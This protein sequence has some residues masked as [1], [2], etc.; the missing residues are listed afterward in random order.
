MSKG[1]RRIASVVLSIGVAAV[2]AYGWGNGGH[3]AV[4]FVA[5]QD[6]T[7]QV[8]DRVDALIKLNPSYQAWMALIPANTP[9]A[10]RNE[11]LFMIAATWPD[12]I[13]GDHQHQADGT[14]GGDRPPDD[15]TA[16]Q[17]IGYGDMAMH[18]YWHF[19]DEPFTQ[20]G[21]PLQDPPTP[22]AE[23]QIAAF[24]ATLASDSPDALK[25]YD[26]VW[27]LHLVGDVHQPLHCASRF[28]HADPN[29]DSGGNKVVVCTGK[30]KA[31]AGCKGELH[32]FWDDLFGTSPKPGPAMKVGKS[33][34]A[35]AADKAGDLDTTHWVQESFD[36]AAH[37][38]YVNP[39]IGLGDGPFQIT[40]AYRKAALSLARE[41][42][43][44]AGSRLANV[45]DKELK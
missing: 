18:K 6:L 19:I 31:K 32:A 29:G 10:T 30:G 3:M 27:L 34:P 14:A 39:P 20:D 21:T 2:P 11:M 43:A 36:D 28:G 4:A 5:Y 25:S 33:L 41:R 13:K 44:V 8:R 17:N 40:P 38:V 35:A 22:N 45:L 26:L 9:P 15:G 16:G 7:P 1:L 23:T 24:R 37:A 42:I 12:Q